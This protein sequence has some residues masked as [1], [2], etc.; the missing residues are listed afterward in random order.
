[1]NIRVLTAVFVWTVAAVLGIDFARNVVSRLSARSTPTAK[2][3]VETSLP[4]TPYTVVFELSPKPG[5][6]AQG[7]LALKLVGLRSDGSL[8]QQLEVLGGQNPVSSRLL[9]FA[10]GS[11][12]TTND[13]LE[14]KHTL[15]SNPN[16]AS[17]LRDPRARCL[18]T[19]AGNQ[20]IPGEEF[21]NEERAAGYRAVKVKIRGNGSLLWF[22]PDLGCAEIMSRVVHPSGDVLEQA[23]RKVIPGEPEASLF[24]L[25]SHYAEVPRDRLGGG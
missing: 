22:A 10:S 25:P 11:V 16:V 2:A 8:V 24:D 13:I 6:D 19:F 7:R 17:T 12:V 14:R 23:P 1:M 18:K 15:P 9:K 5:A 4:I 21:A 20:P 3:A